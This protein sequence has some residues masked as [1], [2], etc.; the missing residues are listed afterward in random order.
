[1]KK[2]FVKLIASVLMVGCIATAVTV[3]AK[4]ETFAQHFGAIMDTRDF[5]NL[6]Y[7]ALRTGTAKGLNRDAFLTQT[8]ATYITNPAGL[9]KADPYLYA[10]YDVM[11]KKNPGLFPN[12]KVMNSLRNGTLK[13]D[14]EQ[15]AKLEMQRKQ[16]EAQLNKQKA[17]AEMQ[18]NKAEALAEMKKQ[19]LQAEA[20]MKRTQMQADA[21]MQQQKM[22]E[23]AYKRGQK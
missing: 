19:Q 11:Y 9:Q 17:E 10:Y 23:E 1:M 8:L 3:P 12:P 5:D 2:T 4:A 13:K 7:Y 22:I 20:E 15:E 21:L 6:Y 18:K 16:I 14:M